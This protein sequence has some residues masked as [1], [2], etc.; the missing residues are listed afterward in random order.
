MIDFV[1]A[2]LAKDKKEIK[3]SHIYYKSS[4]ERTNN[5]KHIYDITTHDKTIPYQKDSQEIS[6][7]EAIYGNKKISGSWKEC[8]EFQE[9]VNHILNS[10][11]IDTTNQKLREYNMNNTLYDAFHSCD[12]PIIVINHA[13]KEVGF[14]RLN[15]VKE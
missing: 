11:D 12:S 5:R 14:Q 15:S 7:Y 3:I 13:P 2:I 6:L 9:A 8:F 4:L 10:W 1:G